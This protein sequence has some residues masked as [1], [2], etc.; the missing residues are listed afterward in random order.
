MIW[1][2]SNH[3]HPLFWYPDPSNKEYGGR[4][5]Y[6]FFWSTLSVSTLS[7]KNRKAD[8][9][10]DDDIR[11]SLCCCFVLFSRI[12]SCISCIV[13]RVSSFLLFGFLLDTSF[14][15]FGGLW[16][17]LVFTCPLQAKGIIFLLMGA[18]V[19]AI[20]GFLKGRFLGLSLESDHTFIIDW[21]LESLLNWMTVYY[22]SS[23][24]ARKTLGIPANY[25]FKNAA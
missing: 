25:L 7:A 8:R 6:Y 22:M 15:F 13:H 10:V 9:V 17:L 24:L 12:F 18:I 11:P 3:S 23:W 16:E 19:L 4:S 21:T 14:S 20:L 5:Y 2:D 1:P